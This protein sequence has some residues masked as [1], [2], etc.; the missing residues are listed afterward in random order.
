MSEQIEWG[1]ESC[2]LLN[3]FSIK[4]TLNAVEAGEC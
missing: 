4:N 2:F 3:L 1:I